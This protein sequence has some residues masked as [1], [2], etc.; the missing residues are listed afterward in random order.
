[1]TPNTVVL[2][3]TKGIA[4]DSKYGPLG[5]AYHNYF[6]QTLPF[7][8]I[9]Y[10]SGNC[11]HSNPLPDFQTWASHELFEAATN[12]LG[13]SWYATGDPLKDNGG[14]I[15]DHCPGVNIWFHDGLQATISQVTDDVSGLCQ[16]NAPEELMGATAVKT[17]S[18][19]TLVAAHGPYGIS[20]NTSDGTSAWTQT[21]NLDGNI[22]E[23]PALISADGRTIDLFGRGTDGELFRRF[24]DGSTW[25][26]WEN[27]GG[28]W[29][30]PPAA[31]YRTSAGKYVFVRGYDG[32]IYYYRDGGSNT[33][34]FQ[35]QIALGTTGTVRAVTPPQTFAVDSDCFNLFVNGS[36][37][38]VWVDQICGDI[39]LPVQMAVSSG[40]QRVSS[41]TKSRSILDVVLNGP[42]IGA[43]ELF[44]VSGLGAQ[45][46][47]ELF[48]QNGVTSSISISTS[49]VGPTSGVAL[50]GQSGLWVG[51]APGVPTSYPLVST[52]SDLVH[53]STFTA[54]DGNV[55][56]AGA[57][58]IFSPDGVTADVF[59]GAA[60]G[61]LQHKRFNGVS[62]QLTQQTGITVQ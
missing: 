33:V 45:I 35:G 38:H 20:V 24:Y 16:V 53:W 22:T 29:I 18:T 5:C 3:F 28:Y 59:M 13:T 39:T 46:P 9:P 58:Y 52:S 23:A 21:A 42:I 26:D 34:T 54:L 48:V 43:H 49:F 19:I 15:G 12:P 36:D 55:A 10:P 30:G 1:M 32:N 44:P 51:R 7:G 8:V 60:N 17:G 61:T 37:N 25:N 6:N 14:E 4:Y 57:P 41:F 27:L 31:G 56:M 11:L 2:V 50:A 40:P 62:W 47:Y